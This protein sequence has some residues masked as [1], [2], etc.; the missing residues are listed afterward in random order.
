[1]T[2]SVTVN[3]RFNTAVFSPDGAYAI[4]YTQQ[5]AAGTTTATVIDTHT[6]AETATATFNVTASSVS[7]PVFSPN[8][9]T[10]IISAS[11]GI[12]TYV[13]LIN[14]T[15][16]TQTGTTR[17]IKGPSLTTPVFSSDSSHAIIY[18]GSAKATTATVI[19]TIT[20]APT[21]TVTLPAPSVNTPVFSPNGTYAIISAS[22]GTNTYEALIN[23]TTGTQTGTT[24]TLNGGALTTAMFSSDSSH[25]IF[26]T[27][28]LNGGGF[29]VDVVTVIDTRTGA[30][31]ASV[32]FNASSTSA[33]FIL[34]TPVFSP[35]GIYAII[36]ASD[37]T[38][39]YAAVINTTTGTQ[40]GSTRT[41][42]GS[43][44]GT[45]AIVSSDSSHVIIL[46]E[47]GGTNT[48]TAT[49]IDTH[50]GAPTA[51]VQ[52]N[53][54][55]NTPVFSPDG[56]HVIISATKG[57]SST[58]DVAVFNTTTDTQIGGGRTLN[59]SF[60]TAEFSPDGSQAII[61]TSTATT[62]TATVVLVQPT[63][64]TPT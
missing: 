47:Q 51:S 12:D 43:S 5:Q 30:P 37:A 46:T 23:T 36:S 18:T 52:F 53:C 11:D 22:D 34:N 58:T 25:A 49:V 40:I 8:D 35:N 13:A 33:P 19:D 29:P 3:G 2:H 39:T 60:K 9:T 48:A 15:T 42:S 28:G 26:Y 64:T 24:R 44:V 27:G 16:G 55:L 10:A 32:Q 7:A 62:T 63:N 41:L 31:T 17:T 50:T 54:S 1:M 59:G 6:G 4:V 56:T 61:Y 21:A 57:S 20:G 38:N 14:T 45:T